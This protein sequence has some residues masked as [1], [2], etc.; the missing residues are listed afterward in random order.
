MASEILL[1]T[2]QGH[3]E[4]RSADN[5]RKLGAHNR[6]DGQKQQYD[7]DHYFIAQ[8]RAHD[9]PPICSKQ[10]SQRRTYARVARYRIGK[11]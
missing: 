8:A 6:D 3:D 10:L 2:L 4:S 9:G 1:Q 11:N 5:P 7:D